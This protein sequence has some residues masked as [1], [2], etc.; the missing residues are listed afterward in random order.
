MKASNMR[1]FIVILAIALCALPAMAD[2]NNIARALPDT[3]APA[4]KVSWREMVA[5]R[6]MQ[7]A[8]P[9]SLTVRGN[10]LCVSSK[11]SQELP[12]Y[13]QGGSLYLSV[14]LTP[15]ENWL[16]GLPRGRYRI[17]NRIVNIL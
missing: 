1:R 13:T 9:V 7:S 3:V 2:H 4:G 11:H 6:Q 12:I 15:G 10:S 14:R 16:F 5:G 8:Y 17:N